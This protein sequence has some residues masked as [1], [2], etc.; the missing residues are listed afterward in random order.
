MDFDDPRSIGDSERLLKLIG[1]L[2]AELHPSPPIAAHLD[3]ALD[4]DLGLDSLSRVELLARIERSFAVRLPDDTLDTIETPRDLMRVL[5]R[6]RHEG[7]AVAA[8]RVGQETGSSAAEGAPDLAQDLVEALQWHVERHPERTHVTF[9]T[10]SA[11]VETLTYGELLQAARRLAGALRREGG[12]PDQ[13][14]ALMLPSGLD[15]FRCFFAILLAGA[16]PVPMY[17]PSRRSQLEDHLRRQAGILG[18]CQAS[19]LIAF[20]AVKPLSRI[21]RGLVPSL[22][23]VTTPQELGNLAAE[24]RL[25]E[26][27]VETSPHDV[28]LVQYTSGSTGDPKGVVLT[29]ANLLANI[30]AWGRATNLT[31]R[32]VCVSWLPLYHDM[33][34]IG[35]WLGSLYHA[36]PLILMSPLDFL[37]RPE[38]WLG[39]IDRYRGTASAAPNFAFDL[40]VKRLAGEDLSG[41]DLSSW[42]LAANGAERVDPDTLE[43]FVA[44]FAPFGFRREALVPVY[45]LAECSVGLSVSP[46][47]RGPRIDVV[48]RDAFA[49]SGRAI[50]LSGSEASLRFVSCG[51]PLAGHEVR[52]VDDE[53]RLQPERRVGLLHFRGPSATCGYLRNP[54]A[55]SRLF[56]QGWLDSGDYAYLA[57]GEIFVTGRAKDL[58]IR[59]GRNFYPY[60]LE[61]AIGELPGVRKGCVAAFGAAEPG[62]GQERLVVV[63]ETKLSAPAE[64]NLLERQIVALGADL[65]GLPPDVV[66]LAPPHAVPKT[67]SGKIRRAELRERYR[68]GEV[69]KA[70]APPWMQLVRLSAKSAATRAM[71]ASAATATAA[72]GVWVWLWLGLLGGPAALANL[73]CRDPRRRWRVLRTLANVC[74]RVAGCGPDVDGLEHLPQGPCVLVA[75]HTSYVDGIGLT[76]ALPRPVTFVGK[77]QLARIP[78]LGLF[79]KRLD[80]HF[81]ERD[82]ARRSVE[83][84]R[85]LEVIAG[86][87]RPLLFFAEGTFSRRAGLRPFRLGAFMVAAR[88]GLPVVPVVLRGVRDFLPEGRWLPRPSRIRVI[89]CPPIEPRGESWRDVLTLRD[90]TREAILTRCGEPS[91]ER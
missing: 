44:T 19:V 78:L 74:G 36:C 30:R 16:T 46:P 32:D 72:Y 70:A 4:R 24:S 22:A 10:G 85:G 86:G 53:G 89:I 56:R 43:R 58:I 26:L 11:N 51:P 47:G 83:D 42:R 60:E 73:L 64:R 7:P 3:S 88:A 67:S 84:A 49:A 61:Q 45:G 50:T 52:I 38:R 27:I 62:T 76:A 35:A 20:D 13:C 48:R 12:G 33:G 91:I 31:S 90:A 75:N 77:A 29:H 66:V 82:D 21:L 5:E 9:L 8:P 59:G 25:P 17:P 14:V 87:A 40:C 6:A 63:A 71:A 57:D 23:K 18:N 65:L 54:A 37:A 55:T 34:L 81:V 2:V 41:L 15:F 80:V 1:Q 68:K 79:L 69:D 39:A 28:A